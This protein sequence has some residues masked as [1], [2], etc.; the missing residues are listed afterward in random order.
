MR[1]LIVLLLCVG[2]FIPAML[3]AE[4]AGVHRFATYN[5][6][7]V[8]ADNGDTG[9]QLWSNRRQYVVQIITDYDFDV[10]GMEEVTGNNKDA[11]TGKSQLQDLRDMLIGYADYSVEREGKNYSYN[12]IFYKTSKYTILDEGHFYVNEHPETPGIGWDGEIERT[13]IWV[14]LRDNASLQ[15][16][17]FVCTHQNYGG[18]ESGVEG[19]KL[20]G[21]RISQLAGQTPVVLVGDF[22]MNRSSHKEAYQGYADHLY[23][24]ALT[25]PANQCLPADGPQISATTTGWTPAT[26]GSTG[27]EFD[28]IFYNN[29]MPLSR[30]IITQ[31]YPEAGRT[32][33]PSDHYPVL[34]RFRLSSTI[35]HAIDV[36]SLQSALNSAIIGDEIRVQAGTYYGNFTMKEGV[37]VSGGWDA[38]FETQ[39]DYASILD[40]QENGRVLEQPTN[41][42]TLT[43]WSNFTIQNG[44]LTAA[45][46]V[47]ANNLGSGV[48]LGKKGQVKHCLIQNNTFSYNGNCMGGGVGN[49]AVDAATDVCAEDCIIRNNCATHGGGARVR[50][51][52]L[53]CLIENNN[54][55]NSVKK[56]PA[57]GVHLQAGRMVGCIVRNNLSG[58]DTGGVRLYGKG[59]LINCL[60]IGNTATGAVGGIGIESANSDVIG[61]TVV[62]NNQLGSSATTSKCGISC[63]ATSDNGTKIANNVVWGNKHNGVVQTA[64]VY[65]ISHYAAGNRVYNAI[66]HQNTTNGIKLSMNNDEDD[67]YLDG[68][69]N[70][71]T[72]LAPHFADPANGDYRLTDESPMLNKGLD[73]VTLVSVDLDGNT[74]I[75]GAHVDIGAYELM[76]DHQTGIDVIQRDNVLSTKIIR[77]GQLI[78]IRDGKEYNVLGQY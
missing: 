28:Y 23:D 50:G 40:A 54:T 30:H 70:E 29:M 37:N 8:H 31:Y 49:D 22:N 64:Q 26:N 76:L 62:D 69:S 32:V 41:F 38:N 14:H 11:T 10:V 39:T 6:R 25:A 2:C 68:D 15:D 58:G 61:C 42:T 35:F 19:A 66:A 63:G 55:N 1:K 17:Y 3:M 74:R 5:I 46:S 44:K 34:G 4:E 18:T 48:A 24:L 33:N 75:V 20:V 36:A 57:G 52:L 45:S 77:N 56:G 72:G 16:F 27:N 73:D 43:I 47:P 9:Q 13:C 59:Q 12:S 65:Y 53:N 51:S 7:Y 78:I 71:Q 21:E 60:I 67:T